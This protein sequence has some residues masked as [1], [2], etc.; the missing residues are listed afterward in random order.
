MLNKIVNYNPG[1]MARHAWKLILEALE[2][3]EG[4]LPAEF[5]SEVSVRSKISGLKTNRRQ[6]SNSVEPVP[7]AYP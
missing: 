4:A 5:P 7:N 3:D 1:V 2:L 6:Y